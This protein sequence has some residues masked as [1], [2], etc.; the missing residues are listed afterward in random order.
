[1]R[2][3]PGYLPEAPFHSSFWSGRKEGK[4]TL[5]GPQETDLSCVKV[6]ETD[7]AMRV[8]NRPVYSFQ[9]DR[10]KTDDLFELGQNV[11]TLE[12]SDLIASIQAP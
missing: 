2:T 12:T 11:G 7:M 10:N 6:L 9:E 8:S 5:L 3:L 1:M 4:T